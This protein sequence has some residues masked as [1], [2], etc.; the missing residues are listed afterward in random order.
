M[1]ALG[2][3]GSP[4]TTVALCAASTAA[5]AA[6]APPSSC[7][8]CRAIAL[9]PQPRRRQAADDLPLSRCRHRRRRAA[10]CWLVVACYLLEG[11]VD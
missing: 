1:N 6:A 3:C 8:Q 4:A 7:H 9:L 5:A 2:T 11:L 10:V